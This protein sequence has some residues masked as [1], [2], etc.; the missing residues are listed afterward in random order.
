MLLYNLYSIHFHLYSTPLTDVPVIVGCLYSY[1]LLRAYPHFVGFCIIL[2]SYGALVP[3]YWVYI[4]L[5]PLRR[6]LS[7]FVGFIY[8]Y[9]LFGG[10]CPTLLGLYI[11]VCPLW[12]FL[13]HFVGLIYYYVLFGGFCP[14]LLGLYYYV[15]FGGFCPTLLGPYITMSSSEVFVPLCWVNISLCP[16]RRFL[17]HFVGFIYYSVLFGGFC[18]TLLGFLSHFVGFIYY[19]V[20]FGGF[21]P[22]LLGLYITM[23][24]SEVFVPLCW[25]YILPCPLRRFLSHFVGFIYYYSMS[26]SEVFVPLCWVNISLCPLRRFLPHFVGFIYYSVLFGGSCPTLLVL[27][28]IMSSLKFFVLFGG[29]WS[30]RV[31]G[32]SLVCLA[33]QGRIRDDKNLSAIA[34]PCL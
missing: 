9:V 29:F 7:H 10:F 25:V 5:C 32:C 3:L 16:L 26:S 33:T 31:L 20:L 11:T 8:Y 12:R 18:P 23:S 30:Q 4:L 2:S 22:T 27:Y 21:C 17:P 24:S 13:S 34:S 14:T 28:I 15:L 19:Y 1:P 6:F